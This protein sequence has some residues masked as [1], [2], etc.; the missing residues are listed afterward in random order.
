MSYQAT[1]VATAARKLEHQRKVRQQ[2]T[3]R[4][5]Q[6][7]YG[8]DPSLRVIDGQ[9]RGTM[10]QI[11]GCSLRPDPSINLEDLRAENLK[12]QAQRR[13]KLVALGVDPSFL[14]QLY[15]CDN[16]HD[17][18]WLGKT[19]CHCLGHF[20]VE[21]QL[22]HLSMLLQGG[23]RSFKHFSIEY[24]SRN[25]W[26]GMPATPYENMTIILQ[27]CQQYA[28]TFPAVPLQ[29]LLF[30]GAPGLGKTYLSACIARGVT[31]KGHSVV[32]GTA[33][34]V[35]N[36]FEV[37]QFRKSNPEEYE[38]ALEETKGY[39]SADLLILDDLGT[40]ST[41][42]LKNSHLYEL[43]NSRLLSNKHTVISTNLSPAELEQRYP[44]QVM[45]RLNGEFAICNFYGDDIRQ[46]I[47]RQ[48]QGL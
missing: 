3:E 13:E 1:I 24:Y 41:N 40:E 16:C 25:P 17:T 37:R 45:S 39:L 6:E 31:E 5:R 35:M 29:N 47:K 21:E 20:C 12:L 46:T 38:P 22:E 33:N 8:K 32:Y 44:P 26:P 28:S 48:K 42:S 27:L 10:S 11:L 14:E 43:I 15:G 34:G 19:M 30:S 36:A 23:Q 18:G 9:L 2:E 4:L 7:V